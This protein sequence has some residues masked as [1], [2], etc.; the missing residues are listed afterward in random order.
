MKFKKGDEILVTGGKDKGKKGKIEKV[1]VKKDG[2]IIAG[3]NVSKRHYKPR[4]E[5]QKGGIIDIAK[6]L[7]FGKIALLCPKCGKQTK[8]G[9]DLTGKVKNRICRKCKQVI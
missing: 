3:I 7:S 4:G 2:V 1:V 6:P 9:Y 5:G 8:I